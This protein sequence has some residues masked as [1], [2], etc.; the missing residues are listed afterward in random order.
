MSIDA[1]LTKAQTSNL[2]VLCGDRRFR[3]ATGHSRP[4]TDVERAAAAAAHRCAQ[5]DL[6]EA[7]AQL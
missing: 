6:S 4:L 7:A 3:R 5:L 1:S 2:A